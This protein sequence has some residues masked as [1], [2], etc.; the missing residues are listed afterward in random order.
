MN[1]DRAVIWLAV[2][3]CLLFWVAVID[4]VM[5]CGSVTWAVVTTGSARSVQAARAGPISAHD[6][7]RF[8]CRADTARF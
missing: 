1:L 2:I 6:D 8:N 5:L 7:S 3:D 4:L